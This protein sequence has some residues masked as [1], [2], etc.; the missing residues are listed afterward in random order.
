MFVIFQVF[1]RVKKNRQK[2]I[3]LSHATFPNLV[4]Q[5]YN[6]PCHPRKDQQFVICKVGKES[7]INTK[8]L[9]GEGGTA[10]GQIF[11]TRPA[12]VA[13][14]TCQTKTIKNINRGKNQL[15]DL[16]RWWAAPSTMCRWG[17]GLPW[18]GV[19]FLYFVHFW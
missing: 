2:S 11:Q 1:S 17:R 19:E 4:K 8:T 14:K 12:R 9:W 3:S 5:L 16:C 18:A 15:F 6:W 7:K 10:E 13:F